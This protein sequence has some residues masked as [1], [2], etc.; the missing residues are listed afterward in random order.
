MVLTGVFCVK[1]TALL[2]CILIMPAIAAPVMGQGM[3][4]LTQETIPVVTSVIHGETPGPTVQP[5]TPE[6]TGPTVPAPP[7]VPEVGWVSIT[8]TP[9]AASVQLDGKDVG[10]TPVVGRELGAGTSH[11]VRISMEGYEP[12]S[13]SITVRAAEQSAV[14]ATLKPVPTPEPTKEPTVVPT[15]PPIGGGKGWIQVSV[16]V[17]GASVSFDGSSTGCTITS[18]YCDTEV[19]VTGTPYRTFTVRMPGYSVYTGQVTGWPVQGETLHL[20]ATLTPLQSFASV[21]ISSYPGG[22]VVYLDGRA[23]QYTPATFTSVSTGADH[24][25]QVSMAGYQTYTTTVFVPVGIVTMPLNVNLVPVSPQTGSLSITSDPGGADIYIDG[26]YRG[27]AP[28]VVPGLAPGSHTVRLQKAG[29][30]EYISA[31]TIYAGQRTPLQVTFS[32]SPPHVGSI[33]VNSDPAGASLFLDGHYMGLTPA[34]ESFDLTSITPGLHTVQLTLE[35][36]QTYTR[37]VQVIAG[38]VMTIRAQL[39]PVP[40]GPVKDTT[41]EIVV[42]STPAGANIFLDNVFRGISPLTLADVPD[43]SHV[44]MVRMDGYTDQ[45]QAVTV[46]GTAVSQVIVGLAGIVPVTTRAP[47]GMIPVLL[48]VFL[49]GV[50]A[51]AR[52][53]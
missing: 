37:T 11:T 44:V 42:T 32:P 53:R 17:N 5:M 21:V 12:Y 24:T 50:F 30:D 31:V 26:S 29:Y 22:A 20:Y 33:E 34:A 25:V 39:S 4:P 47:A 18:G 14:D 10:V 16:N 2:L 15:H 7:P 41:G 52:R 28:A 19:S 27:P 35:D 38:G 46:T 3:E 48:G 49:A 51:V 45:T 43:G 23:W 1:F 36:Y 40:P 9:S 13:A 8:S 6:T